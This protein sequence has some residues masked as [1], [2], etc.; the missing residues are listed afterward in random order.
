MAKAKTSR[1]IQK[2]RIRDRSLLA[3]VSGKEIP[4]KLEYSQRTIM[5]K[6]DKANSEDTKNGYYHSEK[7]LIQEIETIS[8]DNELYYPG[9]VLHQT[10]QVGETFLTLPYSVYTP[11]NP[12]L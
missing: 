1:I 5:K 7:D 2:F 12:K 8:D 3:I 4:V 9:T 6:A 10:T 11:L